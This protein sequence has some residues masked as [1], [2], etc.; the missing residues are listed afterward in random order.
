MMQESET[1]V[2]SLCVVYTSHGYAALRLFRAD[3]K[4]PPPLK[5]GLAHALFR[6]NTRTTGYW[7]GAG[8]CATAGRH[9]TSPPIATA[10]ATPSAP[11]A[12]QP[13]AVVDVVALL[14]TRAASNPQKLN[15]K[16]SIVD[17]LNLLELDSSLGTRKELAAE[18]GCPADCMGDAAAAALSGLSAPAPDGG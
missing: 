10:P 1:P 7:F 6:Q 13:I 16:T 17:S 2:T 18:L 9:C 14:E 8:G 4:S 5:K 11:P 12:P 15:C 3:V